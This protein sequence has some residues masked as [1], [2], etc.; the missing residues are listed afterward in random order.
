MIKSIIFD[1]S[2]TLSNNIHAF[3]QVC[4]VIFTKF[5]RELISIEEIQ[6][7]FDIPYMKFW[8]KYIPE[9]SKE[10]QNKLYEETIHKAD[11]ALVYDGVLEVIQEL[12]KKGI[13]LF[14]VSSDY[15]SKIISEA[16]EYKIFHFFKEIIFEIHEKEHALLKLIKKHNLDINQTIYVGDT[17]GDIYA[18]KKAGLKTAGISWGFQNKEKLAQAKPDFLIDDIKE[19]KKIF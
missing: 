6:A 18:G 2:G 10:E 4:D 9:L 14:V 8:N 17:S 7:N 12:N 16:K 15:K 19:I 11:N 1:W 3:K 5:G 13:Q